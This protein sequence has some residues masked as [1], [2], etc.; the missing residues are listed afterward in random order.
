MTDTIK[1]QVYRPGMIFNEIKERIPLTY[2]ITSVI[3]VSVS[4]CCLLILSWI[5]VSEYDRQISSV[6]EKHLLLAKNLAAK[7]SRYAQDSTSA[8]EFVVKRFS[9]NEQR[10]LRWMTL[11]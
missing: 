3:L 5:Y 6:K 8:F 7:Y 1:K 10:K 2:L 4:I 9:E 11:P